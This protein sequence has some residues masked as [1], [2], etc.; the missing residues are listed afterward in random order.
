MDLGEAMH[1]Y[2]A[3]KRPEDALP[4]LAAIMEPLGASSPEF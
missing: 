4:T 2:L 1:R 3:M